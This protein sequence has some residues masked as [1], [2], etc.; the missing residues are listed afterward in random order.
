V[1]SP[2]QLFKIFHNQTIS[3][4]RKE[5]TMKPI[6]VTITL[7]ALTACAE[8]HPCYQLTGT[9]LAQCEVGV[10]AR[11]PVLSHGDDGNGGGQTLGQSQAASGEMN[12]G[13]T[14][15]GPTGNTDSG[16]STGFS[17]ISG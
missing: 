1:E 16:A 9:A 14:Q 5:K 7:L 15:S 17:A 10:A 6:F 13:E 2:I 4:S 3:F 8:Y 11:M 12:P